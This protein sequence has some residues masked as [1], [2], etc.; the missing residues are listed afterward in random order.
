VVDPIDTEPV[1]GAV[2]DPL[3]GATGPA[4][5]APVVAL[6][7]QRLVVWRFPTTP[8]SVGGVRRALRPFLAAGHL[9]GDQSEDLVLAACE[10]AANAV[11]HALRCTE[12]YFDVTAE[13]G[14][15]GAEVVVRD[16]GRWQTGRTAPG[17][18]G[19]GLSMMASLSTLT[20]TSGPR[21]TSV[22]LR[23]RP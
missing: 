9:T 19:R 13:N 14:G 16:Y 20:L 4:A 5:P 6:R 3:D 21:G 1:E 10:A 15:T 7:E 12:P 22:S 11:E 23:S 8:S 2:H 17:D 18:R